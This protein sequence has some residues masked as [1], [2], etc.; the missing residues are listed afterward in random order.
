M[1]PTYQQTADGSMTNADMDQFKKMQEL[2]ADPANL[3]MII[4]DLGQTDDESVNGQDC[5]TLTAKVIGQK[6]KVWV[7]KT[8]YLIPQW[9]ITLGGA[10][11]DAD[12]DDAFSLYESAF[13]NMPPMAIGDDQVAGKNVCAGDGKNPRHPH[14]NFKKH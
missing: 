5:Y 7:D 6:V 11:S 1:P 10:I 9:Q 2:F 13:T 12:I 3:S 4:K 14:F 8:T